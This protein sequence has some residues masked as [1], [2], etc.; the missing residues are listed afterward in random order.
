MDDWLETTSFQYYL[1]AYI[2]AFLFY[3]TPRWG[4]RVKRKYGPVLH[5]FFLENNPVNEEMMLWVLVLVLCAFGALGAGSERGDCIK[6]ER[7][8]IRYV[9]RIE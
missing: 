1:L 3:A 7:K 9:L 6:R 5:F 4:K 2:M 8:I